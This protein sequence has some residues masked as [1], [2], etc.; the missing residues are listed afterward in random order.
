[1]SQVL[2]SDLP[3]G[4]HPHDAGYVK[5]ANAWYA[6]FKQAAQKG[7]IVRPS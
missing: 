3:D 2:G 1:M 5:M 6:G 4:I 7:W